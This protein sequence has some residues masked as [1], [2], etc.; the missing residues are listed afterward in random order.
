MRKISATKIPSTL[1]NCG[2]YAIT[3]GPH[4]TLLERVETVLANGAALLQYRDKTQNHPRRLKEAKALVQLSAHYSVPLIINDDILLA[5]ACGA[6]G[7]HLGA[8][9]A[10]P[11]LARKELGQ[12][13]IIGVSCYDSLQ[14]AQ[15]LA[16]DG[17][18]YLAFGSFFDSPTKPKACQPEPEI[19]TQAKVI[20]L[21][22][23]AIGGITIDNGATLIMAGA[24]F[25]AVISGIFAQSNPGEATR[26]FVDLF[27]CNFESR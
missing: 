7:V 20:G 12:H 18:D 6:A 16:Q 25:L 23:V 3:D 9:D 1:P 22:L 2:L 21:P 17:V 24:N 14:R 5:K 11:E 19:L 10:S 4:T 26:N 8:T 27:T 13:A 15:K